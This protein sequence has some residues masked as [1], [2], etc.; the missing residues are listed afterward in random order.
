[1][2]TILVT[3]YN[4]E[5]CILECL[6]SIKSQSYGNWKAIILD[7][8]SSD[9]S[10]EFISEFIDGDKRFELIVNTENTGPYPA[11]NQMLNLV[12]TPF[13]T[14]VDGDDFIAPTYLEES[15]KQIDRYPDLNAVFTNFIYH[16]SGVTKPYP[17]AVESNKP[18]LL[19]DILHDSLRVNNDFF[20]ESWNTFFRAIALC[21]TDAVKGLDGFKEWRTEADTLMWMQLACKGQVVSMETPLYHYRQTPN[22]V[23]RSVYSDSKDLFW[24]KQLLIELTGWLAQNSGLIEDPERT[25][26]EILKEY[27]GHL[28]Y[29]LRKKGAWTKFVKTLISPAKSLE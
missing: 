21:R 26:Q 20:S 27:K 17:T 9:K 29:R 2:I 7:N 23:T 25:T 28:L 6:N 5:N 8:A 12:D 15:I 22:S 18:F 3:V 4:F 16:P 19:Q 1:M 10:A 14:R 11:L 13:F 24:K